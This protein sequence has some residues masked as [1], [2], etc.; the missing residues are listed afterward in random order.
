MKKPRLQG[1]AFLDDIR[2]AGNDPEHL[3]IWWLG[4]SGFLVLWDGSFLLVDPY[5]SDS[6]TEK[7]RDTN[8]PHVRVTERVIAP[9]RL[10]FISIVASTHNHT[11]HLD[12]CTL[13][14]LMEVNP[15]IVVLVSAANL[16]FASQRLGV[17]ER[18]LTPITSSLPIVT[19]KWTFYAVPAAHEELSI[20]ENGNHYCIGLVVRAG[21]WSLYH[22]GDTIR[23]EGM[24]SLLRPFRIDVAMLPINGRDLSRGVAGNLGGEEAVQ[25]AVDCGIK[26][27]IPCHYDMFEFNTVSPDWFVKAAEAAAQDY[28]VLENGER[29]SLSR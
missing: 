5:L 4:Q 15:D 6:L 26:T 18:R 3:H 9:E 21:P 27:V 2:N 29:L 23:Y 12:A 24:A 11:D 1:E 10:D 17:D 25:L 14:P 16:Q 22:S 28:R 19:G 20:D 13:K 7:Y 8:K